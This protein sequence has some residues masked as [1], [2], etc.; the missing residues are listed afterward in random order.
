MNDAQ[1]QRRMGRPLGKSGTPKTK[2]RIVDAAISLFSE[3]GYD[4]TSMKQIALAVDLTESAL[5]RH[6]RGKEDLL[7]EIITYTEQMVTQP[8]PAMGDGSAGVSSVFRKLFETPVDAFGENPLALRICRLFFAECPHNEQ[9]RAYLRAA[10]GG[11]ADIYVDRILAEHR[12]R[13]LI[14]PCDTRTVAHLI[15]VIRYQWCYQVS[16]LDR[17]EAYDTEKIKRD[18]NPIIEH[19]EGLYCPGKTGLT[20]PSA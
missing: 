19:F 18:F 8:L 17:D 3:Q 13:G 7:S 1:Q 9:M 16:I 4:R 12:E 10:M 20:H 6:F 14:G 15:N 2:D 11:D 5:Y